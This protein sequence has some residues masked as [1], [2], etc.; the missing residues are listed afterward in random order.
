MMKFLEKLQT[1]LNW[2]L[3]LT[4]LIAS[5][6]FFISGG[7]V[8]GIAIVAISLLIIP[9][10]RKLVYSW[11]K[12][13]LS[14]KSRLGTIF[15]L[16]LVS[17]YFVKEMQENKLQE[18]ALAQQ[19]KIRQERID[20]FKGN[21]DKIIESIQN[22]VSSGD[23]KAAI[24]ATNEYDSLKDDKLAQLKSEAKLGMENE[25]KEKA[26]R[27][28]AKRKAEIEKLLSANKDV[29]EKN[30][31]QKILIYTKLVELDSSNSEF[32]EKLNAY[33]KELSKISEVR[34]KDE[35]SKHA[36]IQIPNIAGQSQEQ[37]ANIL[38]KPTKSEIVKASRTPCPCPKNSYLNG[39]VEIVF[40]RGRADWITVNNLKD[41]PFLNDSLTL[42]GLPIKE[43]TFSNSFVKRWNNI[44]GLLSVQFAPMENG[45]D[46]HFAL[47][48]VVTD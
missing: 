6:G 48:K 35:N 8:S 34:Q 3:G 5:L 29:D 25:K 39:K 23:F 47:I 17:V 1:L 28:E 22:L 4:I 16:M 26:D 7:V 12:R 21:R 36:V 43:P 11:T 18:E 37:V 10:S 20:F 31:D 42:L 9:L 14:G 15:I 46:I 32:K 45:K 41:V 24:A 40:I 13:K 33:T 38:G 2:I 27:L 19:E 30:L 44:P